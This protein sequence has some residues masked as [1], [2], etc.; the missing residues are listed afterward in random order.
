MYLQNTLKRVQIHTHVYIYLYTC[1]R[2]YIYLVATL[3]VGPE[4]GS[5]LHD[6]HVAILCRVGR[7]S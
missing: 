2:V 5:K 7:T 1:V 6:G 3:K 4:V